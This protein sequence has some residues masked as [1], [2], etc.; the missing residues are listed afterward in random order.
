MSS[1]VLPTARLELVLQ[2]P[3]ETLAWVESLPPEV[4]AEVSPAW[5]ER[6]RQTPPG[7]P[8]ALGFVVKELGTGA[9]AGG[10]AFKGP[11]DADGVVEI[12][13]GIDPP[14]Q[15]R[16]FAT[17]AAEALTAFAFSSGRVRTV[18]AHTKSDNPASERVLT[19]CGFARVGEVIDPEDGPVMRWERG[20]AAE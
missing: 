4:R 14:F 20:A 7:D 15:G 6:V 12:G 10:C 18:R 9:T 5:V 16:G 2:T 13:Y 1:L 8:W 17:E 19:K 3:A 11:P